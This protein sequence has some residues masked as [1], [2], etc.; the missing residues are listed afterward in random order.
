[1]PRLA[2][3][4]ALGAFLVAA[5]EVPESPPFTAAHAAAVRDSA[6]ATL[7]A[8]GRYSAA[9]QWDSL[10]RLYAGDA[11][12]RWLEQGVMQYRS[13]AQIQQALARVPPTTRIETTYRDTEIVALAPGVAAIATAFH[14]R[15]VDEGRPGAE[16]GG[17]LNLTLVHREGG[18]RILM[19][20]SSSR[21]QR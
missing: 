13:A 14:T 6:Q 15:F 10:A 8:F 16:F 3:F 19:G 21:P 17:V 4:A 5:C 18:W 12:F 2:S 11:T 20:H 9:G 1:M 7:D